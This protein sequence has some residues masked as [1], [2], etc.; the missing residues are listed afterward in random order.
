MSKKNQKLEVPKPLDLQQIMEEKIPPEMFEQVADEKIFDQ[1]I[2]GEAIGFFKDAYLRFKKNKAS[3]CAAWIILFI[4]LMSIFAPMFSPYHFREQHTSFGTLPPRVPILEN[5]GIA[6]GCVTM[7][8]FE[9][10]LEEF[11]LSLIHI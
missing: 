7:D 9:A 10:D 1:E 5:F 4:V 6:D 3:I 11:G 2:E 8:I